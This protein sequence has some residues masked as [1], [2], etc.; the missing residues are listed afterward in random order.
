ML[1]RAFATGSRVQEPPAR[2]KS[3]GSALF[4]ADYPFPCLLHPEQDEN[5]TD[6][7][8][9][10]AVRDQTDADADDVFEGLDDFDDDEIS[11]LRIA[12]NTT[13]FSAAA[14]ENTRLVGATAGCD[15][16]CQPGI[17]LQDPCDLPQAYARSFT[18]TYIMA[19]LELD[20]RSILH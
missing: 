12:S 14:P 5:A 19:Y 3:S 10:T 16:A 2:S 7:Q 1:S 13:R 18:T 4:T 20:E 15:C 6:Q 17:T 11:S 8:D 9:D